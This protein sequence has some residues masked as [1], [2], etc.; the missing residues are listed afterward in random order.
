MRLALWLFLT[1]LRLLGV[2]VIGLTIDG[3][4]A[5]DRARIATNGELEKATDGLV[6]RYR[7]C[8]IGYEPSKAD[9]IEDAP[10]GVTC[11]W[12]GEPW[13]HSLERLDSKGRLVPA[14]T[15]LEMCEPCARKVAD[16]RGVPWETIR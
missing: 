10:N 12:C 5:Y 11:Q 13:K 7:G 14:R 8:R 6:F 3:R 2:R 15:P 9:L 1:A 4:A 16:R